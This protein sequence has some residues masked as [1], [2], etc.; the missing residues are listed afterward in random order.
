[1]DVSVFAHVLLMH[2]SDSRAEILALLPGESRSKVDIELTRLASLSPE[3]LRG[4]L[5]TIREAQT[6][7]AREKAEEKIGSSLRHAS[8]R[9]V[10]W[11]ARPF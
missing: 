11:L 3:Q 5:R 6:A 10:A 7:H 9:L 4:S 2:K 1:M 8:P